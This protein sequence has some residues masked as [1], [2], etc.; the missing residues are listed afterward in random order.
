MIKPIILTNRA[1]KD[2][3][4]T[5]EFYFELYGIEKTQEIII[6]LL[7]HIKFLESSTHDWQAVGTPDENFNHLKSP[8]RKIFQK[9]IKINYRIGV[10][11]IYITRVFDTR[12]DPNK[13]L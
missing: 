5:E 11:A 3:Y 2:I 10:Q 13:N 7:K 12:Q 9:H 4:N 1:K 8:Y 6:L